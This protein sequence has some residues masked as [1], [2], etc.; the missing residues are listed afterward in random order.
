MGR[1]ASDV[2]KRARLCCHRC[3][4]GI[5]RIA[6]EDIVA[7]RCQIPDDDFLTITIDRLSRDA[8]QQKLFGLPRAVDVERPEYRDRQ[9]EILE[10]ETAGLFRHIL[11]K[12]VGVV[13]RDRIG[14][15]DRKPLRLAV[16][17]GTDIGKRAA[18]ATTLIEHTHCPMCVGVKEADRIVPGI[19]YARPCR[20]V[21]HM[22]DVG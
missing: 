4:N 1:A 19:H 17:I 3:E 22:V 14:F 20:Q 2:E 10:E 18:M 6:D 12:R 11:G 13:G 7:S 5:D 9:A 8:R 16:D 15:R 21:E